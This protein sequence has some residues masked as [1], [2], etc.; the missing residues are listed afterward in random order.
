MGL[1][2][3]KKEDAVGESVVE[4]EVVP[5]LPPGPP[6]NADGLRS[7]GDHREYLLSLVEPLRPFGMSVLEAWN[8]VMCEDVISLINVPPNST[9]KID[10]YAVR[11]A[12]LIDEDGNLREFITLGE[13]LERLPAL[14]AVVV[15]VGQV[16]PRG[17]N[18]VLPVTFAT[19]QDGKLYLIDRVQTGDYMRAAGSILLRAACC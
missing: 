11:A 16:L 19:L 17:A 12:D 15:G 3:R 18:A 9:S 13:D 2:G 14:T 1:F 8:Q 7:V 4:E 6:L 10:G 5:T